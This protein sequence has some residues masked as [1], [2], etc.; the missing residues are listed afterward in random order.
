[1]IALWSILHPLH[2]KPD[3]YP[4]EN[5]VGIL[6]MEHESAMLFCSI[7]DD[8][9]P[10]LLPLF[11]KTSCKNW[12]ICTIASHDIDFSA[13]DED[14]GAVK[15]QYSLPILAICQSTVGSAQPYVA[16][17]SRVPSSLTQICYLH[18]L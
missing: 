16:A 7:M 1:M 9:G 6:S 2:G 10:N 5:T 14:E 17:D 8:D 3:Q 15:Y 12:L 13:I 18:T 11:F 4:S